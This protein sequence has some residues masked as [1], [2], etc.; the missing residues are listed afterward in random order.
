MKS[1]VAIDSIK[2]HH[3][4]LVEHRELLRDALYSLLGAIEGVVLAGQAADGIACLNLAEDIHPEIVVCAAQ[5]PGMSGIDLT[6]RLRNL[7]HAPRVVIVGNRESREW[8]FDAV[9]AGAGAVL[10]QHDNGGEL[11]AAILAVG[12]NRLYLS[13]IANTLFAA[14]GHHDEHSVLT[15]RQSEILKFYAE[16]FSSKEIAYRLGLSIKTVSTH[17]ESILRRLGLRTTSELIRF[18]IREGI[19]EP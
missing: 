18:A 15:R 16:G 4:I 12:Q 10:M 19:I 14:S 6:Q 7:V 9:Q 5:L 2:R 13:P 17:R 3:L 11:V 8:V 1:L